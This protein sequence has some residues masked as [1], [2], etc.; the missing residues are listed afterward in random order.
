MALVQVLS[1][2]YVETRGS[3]EVYADVP[4]LSVEDAWGGCAVGVTYTVH[5]ITLK[6]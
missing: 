5:T 4:P 3:L 1:I 2:A 6:T